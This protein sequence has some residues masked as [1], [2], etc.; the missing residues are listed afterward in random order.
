MLYFHNTDSYIVD[1]MIIR[2][3]LN[4]IKMYFN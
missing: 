1:V 4:I 3:Y 2:L